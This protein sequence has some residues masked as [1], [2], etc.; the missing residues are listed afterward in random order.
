MLLAFVAGK[1]RNVVAR[2]AFTLV[3]LLGVG[4]ALAASGHASDAQPR[5]LMSTAVFLHTICIAFWIGALAP[6]GVSLRSGGARA[7]HLH[8]FSFLIPM[9]LAVLLL[10]GC[11]IGAVQVKHV[12]AIWSTTYGRILALKMTLAFS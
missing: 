2:R 5:W 10:A 9:P 1:L 11:V 8:R 3:A 12:G 7:A 4:L 6:L